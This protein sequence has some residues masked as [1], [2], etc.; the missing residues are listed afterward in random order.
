MGP[1]QQRTIVQPALH[2]LYDSI[3]QLVFSLVEFHERLSTV[4]LMPRTAAF[5]WSMVNEMSYCQKRKLG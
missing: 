3:T 2:S 5:Q 4:F 1:I